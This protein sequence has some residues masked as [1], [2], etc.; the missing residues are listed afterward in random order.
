MRHLL[1]RMEASTM[2]CTDP[3]YDIDPQTGTAIEVFYADRE[4]ETFGRCGAG[5][6]WW[7]RRRGYPPERAAYWPVRYELRSVSERDEL[8]VA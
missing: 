1:A 3:L 7:S 5:W 4:L 8:Q 2:Q 6:F